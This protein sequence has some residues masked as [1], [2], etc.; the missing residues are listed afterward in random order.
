[1]LMTLLL[2]GVFGFFGLHTALWGTRLVI[3]RFRG[4]R[5]ESDS[6]GGAEAN[7]EAGR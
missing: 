1:M 7:E 2:L 5:G 4:E 6:G 3:E